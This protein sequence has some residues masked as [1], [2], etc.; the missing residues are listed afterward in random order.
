[1][2]SFSALAGDRRYRVLRG[3][4]LVLVAFLLQGFVP[5]MDAAATPAITPTQ[6][7]QGLGEGASFC[8]QAVSGGSDLGASFDN[9]YACGPANNK[10]Q[11]SYVPGTG[12][13]RGFF[14][15]APWSYQCT[16]LANRFLFD[17]WHI[18]PVSGS[19]LDGAS[20][21]STV[22]SERGQPLMS[23]GLS[24]EP[25]L[26]GDIVSFNGKPSGQEPSGH[27]A[28]VI[29]SGFSAGDKG[30]YAVWILEENSP[31]GPNGSEELT[32]TNWS[33]STPS[34]SWVTPSNFLALAKPSRPLPPSQPPG[35]AP[36]STVGVPANLATVVLPPPAGMSTFA[37][38]YC[39]PFN[40]RQYVA[41]GLS[42]PEDAAKL[43]ALGFE[44]GYV[45]SARNTTNNY[46]AAVYVLNSVAHAKEYAAWSVSTA[47]A[48]PEE[49]GTTT[50]FA[51]PG[52][53]GAVGLAYTQRP[54]AIA[55]GRSFPAHTIV[56]SLGRLVIN[57]V[58][59][60]P[61]LG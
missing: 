1:M 42:V 11:G 23:N 43:A 45:G 22:A 15:D 35:P 7:P 13:F 12:A 32:V 39:G 16:E 34:T 60:G 30:N 57:V 49:P 52:I 24:G 21:A 18:A 44:R 17:I 53:A 59:I 10:G 29:A 41:R 3:S 26:P 55:G 19:S 36:K 50:H 5:A 54:V 27:V 28:V 56:F 8:A 61:G 4:L 38:S 9:V 47:G 25:Y 31:T 40:L 14:E 37:C 20:F 46:S 6:P 33:L 48:A 51:V 58:I 2:D